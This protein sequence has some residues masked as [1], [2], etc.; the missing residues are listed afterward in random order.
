V[1]E[2]ILTLVLQKSNFMW[3]FFTSD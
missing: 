2:L 3:T 1:I